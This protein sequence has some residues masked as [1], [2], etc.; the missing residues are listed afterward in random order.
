MSKKKILAI[1]LLVALCLVFLAFSAE[2]KTKKP[3][4]NPLAKPANPLNIPTDA[5]YLTINSI[6]MPIQNDA[7]FGQN[8]FTGRAGT[9]WPQG[10][11][12]M[13]IYGAGIWVGAQIPAGG[14]GTKKVVSYG[15]NP[16]DGYSEWG[17]GIITSPYNADHGVATPTPTYPILLSTEISNWSSSDS[18]NWP[19]KMVIDTTV[20]PPET[21]FVLKFA[22]TEDSWCHYNDADIDYHDAFANPG[23]QLNVLV[24]QTTYGFSSQYDRHIIFVIWD[25]F[26]QGDRALDSVYLGITVDPD[27]G[28]PTDDMIG[29]DSTRNLCW[30]Y[31]DDPNFDQD[32]IGK[33]GVMG[34]RFFESPKDT[35]GNQL[36]LTS[37]TLFTIDTDPA[38]DE[39]RYNLMAGRTTSGDLRPGGPFDVD[40]SPQDKRF[41]QSTGPFRL[42]IGDS[43]RVVFGIVAADST[44]LLLERSDIAQNLYN[45]G[46]IT[47]QPPTSPVVTALS[48]DHRVTLMWGDISES[49]IEQFAIVVDTTYRK[50]DFEGY[51]VY[52]SRTGVEGDFTL[53]GE[54]DLDNGIKNDTEVVIDP[55]YNLPN[56][57]TVHLG[58]DSGIRHFFVD[59]VDVINGE[60]YYYA[61][62][63]FDYQFKS[64]KSLESGK[65]GSSLVQVI[66]RFDAAGYQAPV[67]ADTV[68]HTCSTYLSDGTVNVQLIEPAKVTGHDYQVTFNPDLTWNLLDLTAGDT[69]LANQAN[70]SGDYNFPF[71][72]GI[73]ARVYGPLPGISDWGWSQAD[74]LRWLDGVNWGGT[75]FSGALDIGYYFWSSTITDLST[76]FV[77]VE[78]RFSPTTTQKAY[79]YLRG[80]SPN[81]TCIGYFECPFTVWDV[82]SDPPRQLNAA[83]VEQNGGPAFDSTWGPTES[84]SDRE[85]LFVFNSD[86]SDTA[87]TWYSTHRIYADADSFD[88]LYA[89]WP[90]IRDG[91]SLSE[92]AD[93]QIFTIYA[94]KPNKTNDVFNFSTKAAYISQA[95][96]KFDMDKIKVVPNPYFIRNELD[97]DPNVSH[98][99]FTHLPEK[100]TIRIFTLA[101]NMIKEIEHN[102][103]SGQE[104]WNVL[105]LNEQIPA[106]GVYIYHISSDFG[107]KVG[108]FALI[109]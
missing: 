43:V 68:I 99:I 105:T 91:Y 1:F 33:P 53:L 25:I 39:E 67:S 104:I 94:T 38:N 26:N 69:A 5:K 70:Q 107:E 90:L 58:N 34:L 102:S 36:G 14:G 16:N 51:R 18:L 60:T 47:N 87:L 56:V 50:E 82:T 21:T 73:M 55:V 109:R 66:P 108:R 45:V 35:A 79:D 2:A 11:G 48:G 62:V 8:P 97:R 92:L 49:S 57:V 98:L 72:D 88:V 93:G 100:C 20:T 29:F 19:K 23:D 17:P 22:S 13:Y 59:S 27:L 52:R 42:G 30:V 37:L 63:A 103:D 40:V 84:S 85:Y 4:L 89:L 81:Y 32:I 78:I 75:F 10:T 61:V 77:T 71:V 101:G 74:S 96:A 86:Y 9:E 76:D 64:P 28:N 46:F 83:F 106:S 6:K 12:N 31:N 24:K 41:C 15:Y 65:R 95:Q 7:P 54:Y 3:P 80:G 44:P